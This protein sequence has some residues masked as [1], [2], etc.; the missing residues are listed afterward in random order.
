MIILKK[1]KGYIRI[2]IYKPECL[3]IAKHVCDVLYAQCV[4]LSAE[5]SL[6]DRFHMVCFTPGEEQTLAS[7]NT[8]FNSPIAVRFRRPQLSGDVTHR[9][10]VFTAYYT[11]KEDFTRHSLP[12]LETHVSSTEEKQLIFR[13]RVFSTNVSQLMTLSSMFFY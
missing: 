11:R 6:A 7:I 5:H 12:C 3:G 9:S 1:F 4:M 8:F 2:Y 13:G 10:G